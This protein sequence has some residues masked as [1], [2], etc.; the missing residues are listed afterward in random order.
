MTRL[1]RAIEALQPFVKKTRPH[2]RV[3]IVLGFCPEDMIACPHAP[4]GAS[5]GDCLNCWNREVPT[6][7]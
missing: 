3:G 1:E 2:Q 6:N 5:Y 7:D 4:D